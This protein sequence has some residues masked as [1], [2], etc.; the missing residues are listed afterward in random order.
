M[1]GKQTKLA[2]AKERVG[3]LNAIT[4]TGMVTLDVTA[5]TSSTPKE[6]VKEEAKQER[7]ELKVGTKGIPPEPH[8]GPKEETRMAKATTQRTPPIR[9]AI[10][11]GPKI[12]EAKRG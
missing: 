3:A 1:R 5:L 8:R 4:V 11:P 2:R 9:L 10:S 12:T 6:E 7:R